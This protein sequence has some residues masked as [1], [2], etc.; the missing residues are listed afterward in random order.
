[1]TVR[2]AVEKAAQPG[3]GAL[4]EQ[5]RESFT[6]VLPT[7]ANPDQ[8]IRVAQGVQRRDPKLAKAARANPGSLLS[9]LL[10]CARLGLEPGDTYHLVPF[11]NEV[12]GITDY[13][14]EIELIYRAGAVAKVEAQVVHAKDIFEYRPGEMDR[15]RHEADWFGDRGELIGAYAYG[16]FKDGAVS[17]VIVMGKTEIE[18]HRDVNRSS[19]GKDSPWVKWPASMYLKTVAK[20]LRKWVPSSAE[21]RSEVLRSEA[22]VAQLAAN[23]DL[24]ELPAPNVDDDTIDAE[25]VDDA[26]EAPVDEDGVIKEYAPDDPERPM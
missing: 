25:V 9:A 1:M 12:T 10:D 17:R 22:A 2:T 6:T 20:Q 3:A 8:W 23:G 14:G 15:P 21:Y 24:P 13:T 11:G 7:H 26:A 16:V 4:V 5:Y 19:G 18:Q